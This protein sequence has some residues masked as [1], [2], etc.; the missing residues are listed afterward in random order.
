[1]P[2]H[3]RQNMPD[4]G[5]GK[6]KPA[7][8][9]GHSEALASHTG[10]VTNGGGEGNLPDLSHKPVAALGPEAQRGKRERTERQKEGSGGDGSGGKKGPGEVS[11][12]SAPGSASAGVSGLGSGDAAQTGDSAPAGK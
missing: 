9:A 5:R 3:S 8:T 4:A 6:V 1:M 7:K 11:V 12:G 10:G 2:P